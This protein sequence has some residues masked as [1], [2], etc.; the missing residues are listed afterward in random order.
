MPS[1]ATAKLEK[2]ASTEA[3]D[4][5]RQ[6]IIIL[7]HK[8]RNLEKRKR[9]IESYREE[10]KNG[11]DLNSD[12]LAAV[13][14][15][16]EVQQTLEFARDLC[17]Q[18]NGIAVDAAKQHKKQARKEA[19]ENFF[20][21]VK[22]ILLVQDVLHNMGQESVREDFLA[23]R[24]GAVQLDDEDLKHL[25]DLYIE[26]LPKHGREDGALPFQ[27]QVQHSAEHLLSIVEG[28]SKEILGTT[29]VKLK[30]LVTAIHACGYFDQ[31]VEET[32]E[33]QTEELVNTEVEL[34]NSQEAVVDEENYVGET[35]MVAPSD[36]TFPQAVAQLQSVT[37]GSQSTAAM[38]VSSPMVPQPTASVAPVPTPVASVESSY[39]STAAPTFVPAQ[40]SALQQSRPL[41]EVIS[42]V[43]SSFNFLQ[44][45][46]LDSPDLSA[47][48]T[49]TSQ[50][51]QQAQQ[52][53]IPTPP[54]SG[55]VP[56]APIPTQTF[57]NQN[58]AS[59]PPAN[60]A[61][62]VVY[63]SGSELTQSHIPGF[64]ATTPNPPPPIP[65]PP[66]HHQH[67]SISPAVPVA[68]L[69]QTYNQSATQVSAYVS[70][71]QQPQAN[72]PNPYSTQKQP[73]EQVDHQQVAEQM[74]SVT[75]DDSAGDWGQTENSQN[76]W[77][78]Q[79]ETQTDWNQ[80]TE[81]QADWNQ[82]T[83]TQAD[84]NQ[85]TETQ[86]EWN[87][88][89]ANQ[90]DSFITQSNT[91]VYGSGR[92][93]MNRGSGRGSSNGYSGNRGRGNYQNGRGGG[94]YGYRNNEGGSNNYYQNGY[95]QRDNFGSSGYGG[96]YKRGTRGSSRGSM[97]RGGPRGGSGGRGGSNPRGSRG[98]SF[99]RGGGNKQ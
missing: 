47:M 86:A 74:T 25:D 84:W 82:Q 73:Q 32:S 7:E 91:R 8:I 14:K 99:V 15:Y 49:G 89:P 16:E 97:D 28:K 61:Q 1:A 69:Q 92:G 45:S 20:A 40:A 71:A 31:S 67:R 26:V 36:T 18:F 95:Q 64:A 24:N 63:Q 94:A 29:Y 78:Q 12:Q 88:S 22:E 70:Q 68:T 6:A 39:F 46:E 77:S 83:E 79:P 9:K 93:R 53:G 54:P 81:T 35:Q 85:Q 5:F 3:V 19:L 60:V 43:N 96:G 80:Q 62:Q 52:R 17:K 66:S 51:S 87:S 44:E 33:E 48:L 90:N 75:I 2:Q 37:T 4:S 59:V 76:D 98:S 56:V 65:M 41:N 50:P 11:K 55:P 58:F 72:V 10:Q 30:E 38:P 23:G 13:A 42:S 34:Q 21:K 57:T 27:E